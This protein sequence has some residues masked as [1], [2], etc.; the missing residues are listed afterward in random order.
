MD[1]MKQ[2]STPALSR[3]KE[4]D[5]E[6][7]V[8]SGTSALLGWDQEVYMPSGGLKARGDQLALMEGLAH[9]RLA[10]AETASLL[11]SLGSTEGDPCGDPSLPA[12]ERLYLRAF[13]RAWARAAKLPGDFVRE[14][15][16]TVSLSQ[17][18]WAKAR[19]ENDFAAFEPHLAKI[20]SLAKREA[21]YLGFESDPYTGLLDAYEPGTTERSIAAVFG[22]LKE[23]LSAILSKISARPRIDDA[24]LRRHC[25]AEAQERYS[26]R[27]MGVL[28]LDTERSRLDRSVHPFT[29]TIGRGDVRITT[30]YLED[31]FASSISSTIHETGHALYEQG[32]PEAWAG[33]MAGEA[34]SMAIHE[35]Q[36][37]FWE[38][39]VGK[40][41]P[42]WKARFGDLAKDLGGPLD[43]VS[44]EEFH[45]AL[46]KVDPG[47]IRVDADEVSYSLHVILRFE[48]ESAL[49][50]GA[51]EPAG[52]PEAWD[53]LMRKHLGIS[54][55]DDAN[56]CLQD[57]HW[58]I[59]AIGYFPSYALGNLYAAQ[60]ASR[61][62]Q[63]IGGLDRA[64]G[65]EDLSPVLDWLRKNVHRKGALR[66][67]SELIAETTGSALDPAHFLSYLERK[68][69]DI[70]GF[71]R[72]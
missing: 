29:T 46:N 56:G 57:I 27:V 51:L 38:N 21:A 67:P 71:P 33:T 43:G 10:S 20:L 5:S 26:R 16:K 19:A 48:I 11:A 30:R 7:H 6:I 55:P 60:F 15:A 44:A 52:V 54:P 35:S 28:G 40:G 32:L 12:E 69:A 50:S 17:A 63:D 23:G 66:T 9:D 65:S 4:I 72:G 37:R 3:L 47:P 24:C 25:S 22:E 8:L 2:A 58:S 49:V 13:R 36:S 31:Y 70:Y 41:L 39:M 61:M 34:A 45:R 62:D 59:G 42:F 68:F 14:R 64:A 18:V 1:H 53:G